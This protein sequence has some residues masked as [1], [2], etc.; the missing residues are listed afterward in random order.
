[1]KMLKLL[2]LFVVLG[3][4]VAATIM[5]SGIVDVAADEPHSDFV[6]WVLEETR[7]NSIKKAAQNIEVPD[8]SL[9]HI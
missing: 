9:I 8:L 6:Y 7:E 3:L 5:Y 4:G 2:L 1:M